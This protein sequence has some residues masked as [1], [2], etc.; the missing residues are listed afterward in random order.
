MRTRQE[1]YESLKFSSVCENCK[2]SELIGLTIIELLLDVR[3]SL[4][5]KDKN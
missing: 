5:K 2:Y 3:D 1:I 4:N